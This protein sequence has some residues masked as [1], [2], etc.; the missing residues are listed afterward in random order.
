MIKFFCACGAPVFFDSTE[1]KACQRK[2]AF[3]PA[4]LRFNALAQDSNSVV[5]KDG[6]AS[7]HLCDNGIH[8]DV[9]NWLRPSS[10]ES[11]LCF[12]CQ[13]NRYIP[14]LSRTNNIRLWR[15]LELNKRHL[16]LNLITLGIPCIN[17]WD[18]PDEGFLFDF[19]ED[20]RDGIEEEGTF[21]TT[22]YVGGVI[23]INTLE[24]EPLSRVAQQQAS[25]EVYRTVLGHMRHEI[26]HHFFQYIKGDQMLHSS[27]EQKFGPSSLDYNNALSEFYASGPDANWSEH[28]ITA[29]AS[30]HPMEDWAETWSHYLHIYDALD[31]AFNFGL[32]SQNPNVLSIHDKISHWRQLSVALNEMNRSMGMSDIYPFVINAQVEAKLEFVAQVINCLKNKSRN[33]ASLPPLP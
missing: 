25:N 24:A 14:N 4:T 23:T 17:F 21:V 26:G 7:W 5:S 28:C 11:K 10:T 19:L 33:S 15:V 22:G 30:A 6:E 32:V 20:F 18:S 12:A 31:T 9:C 13:F 16:L 2:V 27:F 8:Y 1:C 3:N 29:Y